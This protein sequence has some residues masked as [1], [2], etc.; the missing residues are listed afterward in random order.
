MTD[1]NVNI[2]KSDI[3]IVWIDTSIITNMTIWKNNPDQLDEIQS[4]RIENLYNLLYENTRAGR[5]ICPAAEQEGEVWIDR[6]QWLDTMHTLSLG[7]DC[8]DYKSIQDCQI[9]KSME[10]FHNN[11]ATIEMSYKDIFYEDPNEELDKILKEPFYITLNTDILFGAE[12]NKE[13]KTK[14]LKMLNDKREENVKNKYSYESQLEAEYT[15]EIETLIKMYNDQIQGNITDD[16]YDFNSFWGSIG[17]HEQ[18]EFWKYSGGKK[19]D[20]E[21]FLMF[22]RSEHYKSLPII[23]LSCSLYAKIMTDPQPIRSGDHKDIHHISSIMPFSNLFI[24]DKAWS[25]FLN[26][27]K[28]SEKYNTQVCYVGDTDVINGFFDELNS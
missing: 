19:E 8:A 10:A 13:N 15:G 17:L 26:R 28:F 18:L 6:E 3:P 16:Q 22:F 12:Y 14:L 23:D 11:Q 1:I 24:T 7:I 20:F 25:T 5:V 27:R 9:R 21:G 2:E 4:D